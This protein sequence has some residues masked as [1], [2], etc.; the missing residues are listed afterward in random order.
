VALVKED[1]CQ[2]LAQLKSFGK[3]EK[4]G[5]NRRSATDDEQLR[6]ELPLPLPLPLLTRELVPSCS[7]DEIVN[8]SSKRHDHNHGLVGQQDRN[9][10]K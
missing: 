5:L 9:R 10:E 7:R 8:Q 1:V 2:L 4:V 3:V 6:Q